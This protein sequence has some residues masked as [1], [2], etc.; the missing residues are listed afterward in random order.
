MVALP[1]VIPDG[2]CT[3]FIVVAELILGG[4]GG[5]TFFIEVVGEWLIDG[6]LSMVTDVVPVVGKLLDMLEW[7]CSVTRGEIVAEAVLILLVPGITW[8]SLVRSF[9]G[10][11][12]GVF[13]APLF[14]GPAVY[15]EGV[16]SI[17][18]P[19]ISNLGAGSDTLYKW[20]NIV[21]LNSLV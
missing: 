1:W 12:I 21:D 9:V 6:A 8:M 2:F 20:S 17:T 14:T 10:V 7:A 19:L 13:V 16:N 18:S 11:Q 4:G 15:P 3:V 5:G